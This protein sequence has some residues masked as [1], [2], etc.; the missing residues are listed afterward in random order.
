MT[1][2]HPSALLEKVFESW[3]LAVAFRVVKDSK[4]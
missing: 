3:L 2:S 4:G 1:E